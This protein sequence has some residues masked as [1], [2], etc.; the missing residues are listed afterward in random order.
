M[1][2]RR[3]FILGVG[4]TAQ[5]VT[6]SFLYGLAFLIPEVQ[7]AEGLG[8]A[9]A[10]TLITTPVLGLLCTLIAWGAAADRFGERIVMTIGMALAGMLLLA[11]SFMPGLF[12]LGAALALAG[13]GAASVNAA[14]GRVVLG[15]FTAQERG[16][17]MGIR[18]IAQPVGIGMSA[19]SL[20]ALGHHFGFRAALLLPAGLCLVWALLIWLIVIDPPRPPRTAGQTSS[21]YRT[22]VLWRVHA[23]SGLLVGPQFVAATF[24]LTYLDDQRQWDPVAAGQLIAVV[25][26]VGAAGRIAAGV[27]SDRVGSRLRP[28]RQIAVMALGTMVLWA[29]GDLLHSWLAVVAL[30][31]A[32]IVT[33]TDNGLGYTATAELAGPFW[34]GRALG[35]QNTGQN[36]VAL[37]GT[38]LFG[39]IIGAANYW[40]AFLVCALMPLAGALLTPVGATIDDVRRGGRPR[41][42]GQD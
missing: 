35:V 30:I 2:I 42:R 15:W 4:M 6:C 9:Q 41:V 23:A 26:I 40:T 39:W 28:M 10:A 20:P 22:P 33:V 5:A 25:Q 13:A 21:P 11:G 37:V 32:L 14:S 7:Q 27:W 34:A 17:A 18:Q 1:G 12:G 29:V 3:W 24:A 38:P 16:L 19:V 36:V 8:L 31:A